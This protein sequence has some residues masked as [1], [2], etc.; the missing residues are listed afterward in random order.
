M[1]HA[2]PDSARKAPAQHLDPAGLP[3]F[4][5]LF[6]IRFPI[7]AIASIGHRLSGVCLALAILLIPAALARSLHSEDDYNALL[8][9]WRS[10]WAAPVEFVLLWAFC[11]HV[12]AGVR[13]LLMDI[14]LGTQ[15]KTARASARLVLV[16][17]LLVALALLVLRRWT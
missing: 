6:A 1:H 15:L 9:L 3:R 4:L 10:P 14:G 13:H 12:L 5:N 7:G 16:L 2:V 8:D 17:G 11:Y